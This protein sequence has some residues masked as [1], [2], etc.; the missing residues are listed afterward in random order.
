MIEMQK[1]VV[2]VWENDSKQNAYKTCEQKIYKKIIIYSHIKHTR[3]QLVCF[4][5]EN[6]C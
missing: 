5:V 4:F 3:Y 6:I 2:G 1:K